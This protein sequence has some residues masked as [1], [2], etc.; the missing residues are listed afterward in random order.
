MVGHVSRRSFLYNSLSSLVLPK[1]LFFTFKVPLLLTQQTLTNC[2]K[3]VSGSSTVPTI[4][5]A[6]PT[7]VGTYIG[8]PKDN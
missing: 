2:D 4:V 7:I 3:E 8:P 1:L 6:V 5:G